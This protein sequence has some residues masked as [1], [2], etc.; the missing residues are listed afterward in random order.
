MTQYIDLASNGIS[1]GQSVSGVQNPWAVITTPAANS[2]KLQ[3]ATSSTLCKL[4]GVDQPAADSDAANRLY[5]QQYVQ[6]QIR[7]LQVKASAQLCSKVPISL[8]GTSSI[9]RWPGPLTGTGQLANFMT[10][11]DYTS[12]VLDPNHHCWL[13]LLGLPLQEQRSPCSKHAAAVAGL[14]LRYGLSAL[15]SVLQW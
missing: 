13:L 11:P 14:W 2:L 9:R 10:L 12:T 7:G 4:S 5:V 6:S 15:Q 1:L 8:A 3:G